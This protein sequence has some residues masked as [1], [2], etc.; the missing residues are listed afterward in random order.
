MVDQQMLLN[1]RL[2]YDRVFLIW[3]FSEEKQLQYYFIYQS[4]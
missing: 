1:S 2:N 4:I 3:V